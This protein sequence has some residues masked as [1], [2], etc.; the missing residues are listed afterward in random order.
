MNKFPVEININNKT[1]NLEN[2]KKNFE[3]YNYNRIM[4]I[5]RNDIYNLL[6]S[7]SEEND[8][9]D[10][11]NFRKK[12]NYNDDDDTENFFKILSH[13]T[14]ELSKL[15]WKTQLSYGDTCIFIFS[16]EEK[17]RSCWS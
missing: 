16:T 10:I 12:N 14:N 4:K 17:P 13:I 11:D 7:R 5:L 1:L 9:F 3:E 6:I 15:G 8:Y 2:Y